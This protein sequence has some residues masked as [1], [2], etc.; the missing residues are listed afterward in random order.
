MARPTAP[1]N[2]TPAGDYTTDRN[3]LLELQR[4]SFGYMGDGN[5]LAGS[6]AA[7]FA[8]QRGAME[9]QRSIDP[10]GYYR[11]G[12]ADKL[13]NMAGNDPSDIYRD[14]LQQMT[15]GEFSPD[16]PSY[17]WRFDEGQRMLE[18]SLGAR[19]LLN[20]GNAAVELQERGQ[21]MA[22]TEY[23]AQFDRL[24]KAMGGV[25]DQYNSSMGRLME[26]AGVGNAGVGLAKSKADQEVADNSNYQ[27]G[28][29]R[30]MNPPKDVYAGYSFG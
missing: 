27:A 13:A 29:A 10:W 28:I 11:G 26:L 14:R 23:G 25:E 7:N 24:L 9:Q 21:N 12:A 1:L 4:Q 30:S 18:R 19:G 17:Q 3:K 20:S 8:N 22:S 15:M 16:D 5:S 2:F 6:Q